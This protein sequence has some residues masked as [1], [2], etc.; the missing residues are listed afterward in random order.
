MPSERALT[1][2]W[3]RRD[4]RLLDNPALT[5][6]LATGQPV[7]AVFVND[8]RQDVGWVTGAA[9]RW[10]LHH[11][12]AALQQDLA[13]L[14]I[15]LHFLQGPADK[16][17]SGLAAHRKAA[18]VCW[19]TVFEP[20]RLRSDRRIEA[21]M[22]AA[23]IVAEVFHDD[24][25]LDPARVHKKDGTPY[26][27][28]TPFWAQAQRLLDCEDLGNRLLS[29]PS[30]AQPPL[31][32][33]G[34]G[35]AALDL[36]DPV[37]WHAKLAAHWQPGEVSAHRLMA[38][39][40]NSKTAGYDRGR[41]RPGE[42]ATSK[43]SPA[44]HFGEIS[45]SRVYHLALHGLLHEQDEVARRG[46]QR[47]LTE[48]GWREFARHLLHAF[49]QT[50]ERSLDE[51]FEQPGAWQPDPNDRRLKAWQE[52]RTGIALVDAGMRELWET[53]WMHNRVRMITASFLTK[54][55][56]VHWL[57][58]ARWFWDTLVDADL[59]SNTMGWQWVAGCGSD[60]APYYRIFN[61]H[62]QAAKFDP[63]GSYLSRW[64]RS[65]REVSAIVD[66]KISRG[67]ALE[68]YNS[69]IRKK[70]VNTV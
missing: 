43:L 69:A 42:A 21:A 68:R 58:G 29:R 57:E 52:G 19:N 30:V 40:L 44:L 14:N 3:F 11:S 39:F 37:P 16:A 41:D 35:L 51:R 10:Y 64:K 17:L 33:D 8:S 5:A 59:A 22:S 31:P 60:A 49:P 63:D 27:V 7:E 2:V 6:A 65:G 61:P 34:S 24:C 45:V 53:G 9:A 26:R 62:T 23:G 28:F 4:L 36:L 66:L 32:V 20:A 25:L 46:L 48:I 47:F 12:L 54:N 67:A 38:A 15:P 13:E 50:A 18:R 55:L 56:G 1:L 70:P